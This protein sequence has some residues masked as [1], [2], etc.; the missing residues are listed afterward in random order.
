MELK[1]KT[2]WGE[3]LRGGTWKI[4]SRKTKGRDELTVER[5]AVKESQGVGCGIRRTTGWRR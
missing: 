2:W 4:Q 5:G 1:G 3:G